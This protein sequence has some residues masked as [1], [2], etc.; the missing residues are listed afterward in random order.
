M[1]SHWPGRGC[2]GTRRSP[3]APSWAMASRAVSPDLESARCVFGKETWGLGWFKHLQVPNCI[4]ATSNR[5]QEVLSTLFRACL[6][7]VYALS[8]NTAGRHYLCAGP[9]IHLRLVLSR[10]KNTKRHHSPA[11]KISPARRLFNVGVL[12]SSG[13]MPEI[14]RDCHFRL[15]SWRLT[16][17]LP[18]VVESKLPLPNSVPI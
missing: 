16:S 13:P 3:S 15:P 12:K 5:K 1:A 9:S 7:H 6:G 2:R 8:W 11:L 10:T 14:S 17:L 4:R 18:P